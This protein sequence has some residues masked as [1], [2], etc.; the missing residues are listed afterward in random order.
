MKK[1]DLHLHT[2]STISDSHFDFSLDMLKD[3]VERLEIDCIAITNHNLF[4]LE[5]FMLISESLDIHVLPGIEIDLVDGHLLLITENENLAEFNRKCELVTNQIQTNQ[6][7]VSIEKFEEIFTDLDQYLLIPHYHKKPKI[8]GET[9]ER[10][11]SNVTAGEVTSIKKFISCIKDDES[12]TPVLFSDT[13]FSDDLE[14]FSMSQT[15]IDLDEISLSGIKACLYDKH[16]VFLSKEDGN[17]LFQATTDGLMLSTGLNVL[18]GERSSGKTY[19]LNRIAQSFEN[20]KYIKQFS[21]LQNDEKRFKKLL[22]VRQSSVSEE[23][24]NEFKRV[25]EDI[26][27]VDLH[28]N[29]IDLEKYITSLVKYAS[30]TEK[31]DVYSKTKLFSENPFSEKDLSALK[32]LIESTKVLIENSEYRNLIDQ[33]ITVEQLKGLATDLIN[34]YNDLNEV[35]LKIFWLNELITNIQSELRFRTTSTFPE[36]LDFY[37]YLFDKE[38]VKKYRKIVKE[39]QKERVIYSKDIRGFKIVAK[40]KKY[41]G[42]QGLKDMSRRMLSFSNAYNSYNEPYDFLN[43]LKNIDLEE[44]EYYK[45]FIEIEYE[46]LNEHGYKVSGGERS[47]F[48][49]LHE[50]NDA[51]KHDILLIDEPE[52]SFDNIFLKNEVNALLK[53]ISQSIPV[54]IVT[55]NSTVGASIKP[56]HIACTKKIVQPNGVKYQVYFGHPSDKQLKSTNGDTIDNF[57]IM[58]DCLEAGEETYNKR[59]V[60]SYEILKN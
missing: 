28:Q 5:Q 20:V 3:Y 47:E 34:E 42:A 46:T 50:I 12:L 16:K 15:F 43:E 36:N 52:S 39:L 35:N 4:D 55:H 57:Q 41:T 9:L 49:L 8:G 40:S 58:L 7:S 56:N 17:D 53:E 37:R 1:I 29:D 22:T 51:L 18:L 33:H 54:I 19:T 32:K 14:S 13:R 25:I 2:K 26:I 45:Y 30:E 10:L 60:E 23:Y 11:S 27:K 24:L 48:N 38:K 31:E 21:L 6:D 59:R 44:T